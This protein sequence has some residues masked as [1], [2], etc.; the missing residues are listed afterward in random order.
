MDFDDLREYAP[1]DDVRD[2][3]W[4]ATARSSSTLIRRYRT[5][6]KQVVTFLVDGGLAM[7][8]VTRTHE[9]KLDIALN[10]VGAMAYLTTKHGDDVGLLSS[11]GAVTR[12]VMPG[13]SDSHLERILRSIQRSVQGARVPGDMASLLD[14]AARSIRRRMILVCITD[15]A[16][17]TPDVGRLLRTV[18]TRH[19]VL[20]LSIGDSDLSFQEDRRVMRTVDIVRGR[21]LPPFLLQSRAVQAEAMVTRETERRAREEALDRAGVSHATI[22]SEDD[23]LPELISLFSRR[24]YARG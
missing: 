23:V 7:T 8:A 18:T 11:D 9:K 15:E 21:A 13:R 10:A 22:H 5:E 3:D 2:I 14:A 12:R 20:W 17:L 4:N 6:R 19:E 1:G 24:G 16:P